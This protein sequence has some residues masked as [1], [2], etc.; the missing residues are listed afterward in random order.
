MVNH[1]PLF[2]DT[3]GLNL[4]IEG[5]P[6]PRPGEEPG[7][8]Y[9]VARPGYFRT[10][11]IPILLGRDFTDHDT[12][13]TPPVVI[14][15]ER[16]AK[17][18]WPDGGAL[19]KRLTIDDP[20]KDPVWYTIVGVIKD[21]K[22]NDWAGRPD[23]EYYFAAL[24]N[25]N[26]IEGTQPWYS[27]MTLVIRTS[28]DP[29]ALSQAVQN[30]V[31]SI[32]RSLPLASLKTMEQV[33]SA[34]VW[35]PRFNLLLVGLFAALALILAP[36]G[37]YGV[38]A[39][40]VTERTHEIGIRMALGA[41]QADVTRMVVR[42]GMALAAIGGAIG[43][44]GALALTRLLGSLLYQVKATDPAVFTAIPCLFAVV[45]VLASYIPARR[46]TRVDPTI[47]LHWE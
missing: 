43:L 39:Y 30:T 44:A 11:Q 8:I 21:V 33:I 36:V 22:Q 32:D 7:A 24:Q 4:T 40:S 45:A 10:M 17:A 26:I 19:G 20:R 9:R 3:W 5:R 25:K 12:Q 38:M 42:E 14:V 28:G 47:A 34:S 31:W 1:L 35:Q 6:L 41:K 27:Y 16:L 2:G 46:A 23:Y 13:S 29:A 37:I 15:N 18:F